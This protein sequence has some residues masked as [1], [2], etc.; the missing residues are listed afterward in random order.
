VAVGEKHLKPAR[1]QKI[2]REVFKQRVDWLRTH[3]VNSV[4]E[5]AAGP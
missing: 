3:H 4:A 5:E 2:S 1:L